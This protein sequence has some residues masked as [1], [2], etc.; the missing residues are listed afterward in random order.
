MR[1]DYLTDMETRHSQIRL[2]I[3]APLSVGGA[4]SLSREHAHYLGTVMRKSVGYKL[5]IF[6][7]RDGCFEAEITE[8]NRKAGSLLVQD[9]MQ[10]QWSSPD[11]WFLFAPVK[12]AR[13]DYMAQ[14]ATE[15]GASVIWP[16]RTD[17][18]QVK[19]VKDERLEANAIEAA[20]QTERL[21]IPTIQ[22]FTD[23]DALLDDWP[24]DRLLFFCDERL[25][26][27]PP[28]QSP[29]NDASGKNNSGESN[30][31]H[32]G[33]AARILSQIK[34][35]QKAAVL[36]GPE[37]GFSMAEKQ[38]IDALPASYGLSLGPRI[39]RADTAAL[40]VLSLYQAL[41]GDW[42]DTSQSS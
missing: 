14:K 22:P 30:S 31:D 27:P 5:A 37:G 18:C 42:A 21:D 23:L 9:L 8:L 11:L 15:L 20:E 16:V 13:L 40:S 36:I 38:K 28:Q 33:N 3:D 2:Y 4:V 29:L 34:P 24:E 6:N 7:G 17:Y 10:A 26:T 12:R 32:N 39:L 41:C 19:S 1:D 35:H 25:A